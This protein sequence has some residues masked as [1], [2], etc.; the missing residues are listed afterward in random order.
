MRF[1]FTIE[2][3]GAEAADD[4]TALVTRNLQRATRLVGDGHTE[5]QLYDINGNRAGFWWLT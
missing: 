3:E 2:S 5:G 1:S 4:P